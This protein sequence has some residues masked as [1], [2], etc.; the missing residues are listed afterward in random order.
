MP[1][2]HRET[3]DLAR[4]LRDLLRLRASHGRGFLHLAHSFSLHVLTGFLAVAAH[5]GT[6]YALLRVQPDPLFA[7]TIGFVAGGSTR[8]ALSFFR[9][10]APTLG[11]RRAGVRFLVAIALQALAN[12]GLLALLIGAGLGVWPAQV[13]TTVALA[14]ATYAG[15]RLWVFR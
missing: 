8:F 15:Y 13:T 11:V 1:A 14:F 4:M 5:Y 3:P 9:V 10:F 12:T 7:S 2:P 6:M